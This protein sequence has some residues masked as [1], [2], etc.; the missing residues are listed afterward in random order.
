VLS[1]GVLLFRVG[2]LR[3]LATEREEVVDVPPRTDVVGRKHN[4]NRK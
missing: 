4:R 2:A 3:Q 1:G